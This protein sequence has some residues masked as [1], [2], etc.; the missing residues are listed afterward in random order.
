MTAYPHKS[1][2]DALRFEIS[3]AH[4]QGASVTTGLILDLL[5]L[6][7]AQAQ[8]LAERDPFQFTGDKF[9]SSGDELRTEIYD[10]VLDVYY[11]SVPSVWSGSVIISA[12]TVE[13]LFD[14]PLQL[15]L[16]RLA[17]LGVSRSKFQKLIK[18][19]GDPERVVSELVDDANGATTILDVH[20]VPTAVPLARGLTGKLLAMASSPCP[21][22]S[23]ANWNVYERRNSHGVC[24]VHEGDYIYGGGQA[25]DKVFGPDTKE[26]CDEYARANCKLSH[27]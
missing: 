4:A 24:V 25:Y 15:E 12:G 8:E 10:P 17:S 5:P 20:L 7:T 16:P 6:S 11:L 19:T 14:T 3:E 13:I 18:I 1:A 23:E 9:E 2:A 22:S 27:G 26:A 21:T